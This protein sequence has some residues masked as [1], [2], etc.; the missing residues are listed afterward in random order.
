MVK[1][2]Q[3]LRKGVLILNYNLEKLKKSIIY[4]DRLAN[5]HNPINNRTID[6]MELILKD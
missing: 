5:E 3:I 6:N 2:I 4:I 1:Y